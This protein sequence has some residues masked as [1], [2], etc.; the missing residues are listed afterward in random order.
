MKLQPDERQA[1]DVASLL[2]QCG[3]RTVVINACRSAAG[4]NE[5]SNI[6]RLLVRT[7]IRVA[8]GMS[9]NVFS[10][11]ADQFMRDFYEHFLGQ[12]TSPIAA[13][14]HA[15]GE[16][17][18]NSTRMS[19]YHTKISIEDHLVPIIHC[20]ES[21][22]EELQQA[23]LVLSTS[24]SSISGYAAASELVGREGDLLRLEWLL[25]QGGGSRIH[26]QGSPGVGKSRLLQEAS[27]WWQQTGLFQRT[28]Y[29][30]LTDTEFR[31][32]TA[33][34]I[35][36]SMASRTRV[37]T[38]DHS[39]KP[40]IATLDERSSLIVL[41]S[42]DAL[43]W[44]SD[45]TL[46]EHQRQTRLCLLRLKRCSVV[47]LSR[48][49]DLWLATAV[50]S[51][52]ILEPI[53]LPNTIALATGILRNLELSSKLSTQDDQSY[54]EQ[55]VTMSQGNPLA[56]RVIVYDLAK[57]LADDPSATILSHLLSLLQLR[58]VFLDTER[59][60]SDGE[61]RA[62][63]DILEWIADDVNTDSS[64]SSVDA[65]YADVLPLEDVP[66]AVSN[67]SLESLN[68]PIEMLRQGRKT[69]NSMIERPAANRKLASCGF[70]SA[71]VFLGFWHNLPHNLEPFIITFGILLVVRRYLNDEA[72]AR[73]RNNLC[74]F[75]EEGIR[76]ERNNYKKLTSKEAFGLSPAIAH[77]C[78]DA[79]TK[80]FAKFYDDRA[81]CLSHF[82][83]G[84]V[85]RN[86]GSSGHQLRS[87]CSSINPLITLVS[88]S[89]SVRAL[90][91]SSIVED[92]EIARDA[93]CRYRVFEWARCSAYHPSSP[94]HEAMKFELDSDFFNYLSLIMSYQRADSWPI[95]EHWQVQYF[96]STAALSDPRRLRLVDRV[97]RLFVE[98][99]LQ[100][101]TQTRQKFTNAETGGY[102]TDSQDRD[103]RSWS[104]A[105]DLE[106]A[107]VN[108]LVRAFFCSDLLQKP[109]IEYLTQWNYLTT[110]PMFRIWKHTDPDL[111]DLVSRSIVLNTQ[112]FEIMRGRSS[113]EVK[114]LDGWLAEAGQ[115][116]SRVAQ[117]LG[118]QEAS[119]TSET[120][121]ELSRQILEN[122]IVPFGG[123]D[124]ILNRVHMATH[125]IRFEEGKAKVADLQRA[126]GD[127]EALLSEEIEDEN[128]VPIRM[129]IHR[130]LAFVQDALG[131]KAIAVQH[132]TIR[133]DLK[134]MLEP[135]QIAQMQD[136]YRFSSAF[137][138]ESQREK[139]GPVNLAQRLAIQLET[140]RAELAKAKSDEPLNELHV[141]SCIDE[142]ADTLRDLGREAEAADHYL[143]VIQGRRRLLPATD[144]AILN[145]RFA[146]SKL[147]ANLRRYDESIEELRLLRELYTEI[148]DTKILSNVLGSLGLN[149]QNSVKWQAN[150]L[151][152]T[153][154]QSR[155]LEAT[156]LL[157]QAV[158]TVEDL[159]EPGD[160]NIAVAFSNLGSLYDF[161]GELTKAESRYQSA[162][163]VHLTRTSDPAD[164]KLVQ[165]RN[166][167]AC[168][169][170][171][172]NKHEEAEDLFSSLLEVCI[173]R[174]EIWHQ[175]SCTVMSN[176]HDIYEK[177][178]TKEKAL[179]LVQKCSARFHT[180]LAEASVAAK[181]GGFDVLYAKYRFGRNLSLC[182]A[183]DQ[184]I[185]LLEE[186]AAA[187]R[188]QEKHDDDFIDLLQ[189]LR[190]SYSAQ[191][192]RQLE[193]EHKTG[194]ELV[195]L[196]SQL[197]GPESTTTLYELGNLVV[198]LR[199]LRRF[200][201]AVEMQNRLIEAR[202]ATIGQANETTLD[203]LSYLAE[204]YEEIMDWPKAIKARQ[205]L[206]L[207]RRNM[208][209]DSPNTIAQNSQIA[210]LY[211]KLEKWDQVIDLRKDEVDEWRRIEGA[212]SKNAL[213]ALR[214]LVVAFE[215]T[216][217]YTE[218]RHSS[219]ELI[220]ARS[221][222]LGPSHTDTLEDQRIKARICRKVGDF[223]E[224]QQ[225]LD[226]VLSTRSQ[227]PAQDATRCLALASLSGV[228]LARACLT[229]AIELFR[230][231]WSEGETV[232]GGEHQI[233][234]A[235]LAMAIARDCDAVQRWK[236]A[237]DVVDK[238][239]RVW[240]AQLTSPASLK[241]IEECEKLLSEVC[242]KRGDRES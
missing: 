204:I 208:D 18:R 97:L 9:F 34:K 167:L 193:A 88:Q 57:H 233:A 6:A 183:H 235:H 28:I 210:V 49:E 21:E 5:A 16:L 180:S 129:L 27:A 146:R 175:L 205:E 229:R 24:E 41:D 196:R 39:T 197:D 118:L 55:L 122:T 98:K 37:D 123:G 72:F 151:P 74:E 17:R 73:F 48:T 207:A 153:T 169:W 58:P 237:E 178:G 67:D 1:A 201:E 133:E 12:Q 14:S 172:M 66:F 101:I 140:R 182:D 163:H 189:R 213:V 211:E 77:Y 142:V 214:S 90:Y 199:R 95:G 126:I 222:V 168:L 171:K 232:Q 86:F 56:I 119:A 91:P 59:L 187:W 104:I 209:P 38:S 147:L 121:V 82:V 165:S 11:S 114:K 238:A 137:A 84:P 139:G 78:L 159:F 144:R 158:K 42:I 223:D 202:K 145:V 218:A 89:T 231:A 65:P 53:D 181:S 219:D 87:L 109:I 40:L 164:S 29:I 26:L 154:Q 143:L 85:E 8:V 22:I 215:T 112:G 4:S 192:P 102:D 13:V 2:V 174:Y 45:L 141:L 47:I 134:T 212:D 33:D 64:F 176:L 120:P 156:T 225:I 69:F 46:S 44:S 103:Y 68:R 127:L 92:I 198:C 155:L 194:T 157:E 216:Q 83:E 111:R 131:N 50:Q 217:R 226:Q 188:K 234:L 179:C 227:F 224:A 117:S 10:L 220:E 161:R 203:N 184:A 240:R 185:L 81:T 100:V 32:C 113:F 60:A 35:L 206:Y 166:N 20:Q 136:P 186:V 132:R 63:V 241:Q 236:D 195:Q 51:W 149:L 30:R 135:E 106:M 115:L 105:T 150:T 138:R 23:E 221:R 162:I 94:F 110:R 79:A 230:E 31:D 130:H 190:Y 70:Y 61:T 76:D 200:D 62:V 19:K 173:D 107:T 7:G 228:S 152:K 148:G 177:N 170:E 25:A 54:F 75:S 116:R 108:A 71:A 36:R 96:L 125:N 99:A 160:V 80:S 43:E 3:V 191:T 242:R 128:S 239:S 15:R 124:L 52:I 93:Q